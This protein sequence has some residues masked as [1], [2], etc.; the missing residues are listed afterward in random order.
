MSTGDKHASGDFFKG[1]QSIAKK[2]TLFHKHTSHIPIPYSTA[3]QHGASFIVDE[4]QTG[5]GATGTMW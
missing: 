4:V 1:V 5:G 2:V 3:A